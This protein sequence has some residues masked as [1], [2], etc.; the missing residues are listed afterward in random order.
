MNVVFERVAKAIWCNC[1]ASPDELFNTQ[2]GILA[3][4]DEKAFENIVGKEENAD[5]QH[6]LFPTMF[7]TLI[8]DINHH[9]KVPSLILGGGGGGVFQ[10]WDFHWPTHSAQVLV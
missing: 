5:D 10:L 4:L 6:F 7:S 8:K 2:P 1:K 9:H 3:T